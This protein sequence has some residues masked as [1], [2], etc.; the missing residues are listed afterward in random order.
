MHKMDP[1]DE[2]KSQT[3]EIVKLRDS[4]KDDGS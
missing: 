2:R 4:E 1:F 3:K